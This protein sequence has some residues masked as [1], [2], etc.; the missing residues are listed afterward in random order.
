MKKRGAADGYKLD[1]WKLGYK[2][3]SGAAGHQELRP[4]YQFAYIGVQRGDM[5]HP[6]RMI[7]VSAEAK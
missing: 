2:E 4:V 6:P 5:E 1:L 7:E 3:E